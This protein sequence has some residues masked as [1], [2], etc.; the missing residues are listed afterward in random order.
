MKR[1]I[2]IDWFYDH[3]IET[4]WECLTNPEML[5]EWWLIKDDFR[6][7]V[8]FKWM[9]QQPPR[10]KMKWDGKIYFEILEVVPTTKLVYSFKG[11]PKEGEINLD[12]L[13]TWTLTPKNNGTHLRLEHTGF[14]G[15]MNYLSSYIME[16]GWKKQVNKRFTKTLEKYFNDTQQP[17]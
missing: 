1:D 5:K 17:V 9:D 12:T 3:P 6:A 14:N 7:E 16:L 13:V 2:K 4:V 8:G 10:P 15:A 11:G